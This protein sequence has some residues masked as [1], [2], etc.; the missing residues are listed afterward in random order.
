MIT[1]AKPPIFGLSCNY[2]WRLGRP[3]KYYEPEARQRL[4]NFLRGIGFS[5][6][7]TI[8]AL[9]VL[10]I[11]LI[12]WYTELERNGHNFKHVLMN[13]KSSRNNHLGSEGPKKFWQNNFL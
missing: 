11:G 6:R 5:V 3:E 10:T 13:F 8:S 12:W 7:V 2:S 9:T 4:E 1:P